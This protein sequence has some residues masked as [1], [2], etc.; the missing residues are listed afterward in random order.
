MNDD[1]PALTR[2]SRIKAL[3]GEV[4]LTCPICAHREFL[5]SGPVDEVHRRGFRHVIIGVTNDN[6]L[7]Y[8]PVRFFACANCGYLLKFMIVGETSAE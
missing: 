8:L 5:S 2:S 7:M 6:N 3:S 4:D 1:I